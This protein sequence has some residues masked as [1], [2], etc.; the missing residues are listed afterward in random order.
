MKS[1]LKITILASILGATSFANAASVRIRCQA[2]STEEC[3]TRITSTLTKMKCGPQQVE[4]SLQQETDD[5]GKPT[6]Q[7]VYCTARTE[8]CSEASPYLFGGTYCSSGE[9]QS[10]R[11]HDGKL[12]L[13]YWMGLTGW[14]RSLCV[15]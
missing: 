14:V 13:T 2:R 1:L 4:C 3:Q 9:K 7:A 10:M 6:Q 5:D 8:K 12:T 15:N 11:W